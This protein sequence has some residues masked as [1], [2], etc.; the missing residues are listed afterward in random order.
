[1]L[2][3]R[4]ANLNQELEL[5]G[6]RNMLL[7]LTEAQASKREAENKAISIQNE[8]NQLAQKMK[9]IRENLAALELKNK[10]DKENEFFSDAEAKQAIQ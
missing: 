2:G 7:P 5:R 10:A 4:I 9:T 6:K 8:V 3:K 1:M